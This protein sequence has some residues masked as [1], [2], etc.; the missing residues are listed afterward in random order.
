MNKEEYIFKLKELLMEDDDLK[1]GSPNEIIYMIDGLKLYG[2]FDYGNRSIDHNILKF[3]DISW[4]QILNWGTLVV[5]ETK[6]YISED[7]VALFENMHYSRLPKDENHIA[8]Y[9]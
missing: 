1:Y 2:G 8:G 9:N 4:E 6:S 7:P 3:D 5:P